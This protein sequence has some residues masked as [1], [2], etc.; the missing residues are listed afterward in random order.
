MISRSSKLRRLRLWDVIFYDE[1]EIVDLETIAVCLPQ[2]SHLSLSYDLRDGVLHY[3]LQGSSHLENVT[4]LELGW[5]LI[6]DLF[7]HFVEGLLKR[8]PSLKKL[9]IHGVVS[10]AKTQ[11]ECQTFANFTSS[12]VQL[13]RQYMYVEVQFEYE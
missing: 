10:E 8:C 9:V 13:M 5:T 2:L 4:F 3:G 1:D 11:E 12:I 6:N 7:I